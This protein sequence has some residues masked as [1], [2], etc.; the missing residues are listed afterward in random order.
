M[1]AAYTLRFPPP[2]RIA[3]MCAHAPVRWELG[4]LTRV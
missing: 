3:R 2:V 1:R 4:C